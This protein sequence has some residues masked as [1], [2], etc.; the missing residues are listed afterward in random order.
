[1]TDE[2]KREKRRVYKQKYYADNKEEIRAK[3]HKYYYENKETLRDKN[4]TYY[5]S[6]TEAIL[7][8]KK[9]HYAENKETFRS[10][11]HN[12]YEENKEEI[13][14][15][16]KT[17]RANIKAIQ[18]RVIDWVTNNYGDTPCIDC[19]GVFPWCVMDFDH[20]PGEVKEFGIGRV[21]H[22]RTTPTTIARLEKEIAKCDLVC[23]NCHRIRTWITRK[24]DA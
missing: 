13:R 16:S 1:M 5:Y 22:Y 4:Q 6:N 18:G 3:R 14:A 15:K 9:K 11:D 8:Q 10:R 24:Q 2:E 21:G 17:Y 19:G 7:A 23:A 20:R 12:Y